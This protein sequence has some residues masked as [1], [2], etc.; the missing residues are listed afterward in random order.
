MSGY[1]VVAI[2]AMVLFLIVAILTKV[3]RFK[4]ESVAG[5]SEESFIDY[6]GA[7]RFTERYFWMVALYYGVVAVALYLLPG[8]DRYGLVFLLIPFI[9]NHIFL[10]PRLSDYI[11]ED[12]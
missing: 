11:R 6:E 2:I 4:V 10:R 3:G 9:T 8:G 12:L 7:T 5:L 1:G